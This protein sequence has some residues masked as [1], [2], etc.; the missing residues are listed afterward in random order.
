[1]TSRGFW[2]CAGCVAAGALGAY[3]I[4]KH[5]DKVKPMAA[6]LVAKSMRLKDKALDY[7][8]RTKEHAEDIVAEARHINETGGEAP[9]EG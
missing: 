3:L 2:C 4:I 5:K 1:M 9:A 6:E 7:A 8:A